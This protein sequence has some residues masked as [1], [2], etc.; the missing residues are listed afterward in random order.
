MG[1]R[2]CG[3]CQGCKDAQ[4]TAASDWDDI[5]PGAIADS[6]AGNTSFEPSM[7]FD[8]T[9]PT[10]EAAEVFVDCPFLDG[11]ITVTLHFDVDAFGEPVPNTG[12]QFQLSGDGSEPVGTKLYYAPGFHQVNSGIDLGTQPTPNG[13]IRVES[14]G[15]GEM[16]ITY[17]DGTRTF[18]NGVLT[19]DCGA[20][21]SFDCNAY[22]DVF[23][24]ANGIAYFQPTPTHNTVCDGFYPGV[25]VIPSTRNFTN[26]PGTNVHENGCGLWEHH[27][28]IGTNAPTCSTEIRRANLYLD[29]YI[30]SPTEAI[31]YPAPVWALYATMIG[32][33]FPATTD[34]DDWQLTTDD[35]S[36]TYELAGTGGNAG[37]TARWVIP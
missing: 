29:P 35:I 21:P 34:S 31:P 2:C 8:G 24:V 1:R 14:N 16:V 36:G 30:P 5:Q 11:D 6:A 4:L 33:P 10:R 17:N 22:S 20:R 19:E 7:V 12:I 13:R 18:K 3:G 25:G 37:V 9:I 23:T 15:Y 32:G 26:F 28:S 27:W